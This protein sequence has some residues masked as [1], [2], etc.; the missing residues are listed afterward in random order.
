M[1]SLKYRARRACLHAMRTLSATGAVQSA[2]A[3]TSA[4]IAPDDVRIQRDINFLAGA[5]DA[6]RPG[7][8]DHESGSASVMELLRLFSAQ[9][10]MRTVAFVRFSREEVRVLGSHYIVEHPPVPLACISAVV[11]LDKTGPLRDDRL[12]VYRARTAREPS[13]IGDSANRS[14]RSPPLSTDRAPVTFRP[15]PRRASRCCTSSRACM[16]ATTRPARRT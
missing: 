9:P 1:R 15:F 5:R 13:A 12:I 16:G 10:A 14:P 8:Y 6:I 4:Q 2:S 3:Q 11:N 7:S